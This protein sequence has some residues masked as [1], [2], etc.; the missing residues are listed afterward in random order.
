[1]QLVQ[2]RPVVVNVCV[3]SQ[4]TSVLKGLEEHES[5]FHKRVELLLDKLVAGED[6][7]VLVNDWS[8]RGVGRVQERNA[9]EEL[10]EEAYFVVVDWESAN[11][12][13]R[14]LGLEPHTFHITL[15]TSFHSPFR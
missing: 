15:G 7:R 2:R 14:A 8:A 11:E 9:Q 3:V 12:A 6:D 13:R 1:M 5:D 4:A 10:Q